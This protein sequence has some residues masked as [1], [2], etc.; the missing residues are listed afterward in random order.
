[1]GYLW[2]YPK[3]KCPENCR[4]RSKLA[5]F[6]GYCMKEILEKKN[7]EEADDGE[8]DKNPAGQAGEERL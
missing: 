2:E 4:Y 7:T 5:P 8:I 3:R 6:C 1:M